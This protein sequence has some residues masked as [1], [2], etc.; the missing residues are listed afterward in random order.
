M[1]FMTD[2]ANKKILIV[3]DSRFSLTITKTLLSKF[4]YKNIVTAESGED[5]LSVLDETCASPSGCDI[6]IVMLDVVMDGI[7]G[8]EVCRR[9]KGDD[10]IKDVPVLM[11]TGKE[12]GE[13]MET[14]FSAGAFDFV[15]KPIDKVDL[16]ARV[17][18]SLMLKHEVDMRREL[19]KELQKFKG[20]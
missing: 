16:M 13:L 19:E 6:D 2:F 11:V 17:R 1:V 4:G 3:D 7:D 9:I 18:A 20:T 5:A 10:R 8:I 12:K 14:A 15:S